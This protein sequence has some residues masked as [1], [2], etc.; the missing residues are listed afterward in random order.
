MK[1]KI[2]IWCPFKK[3]PSVFF[4]LY[5]TELFEADL[6]IV[7]DWK[8]KDDAAKTSLRKAYYWYLFLLLFFSLEGLVLNVIFF[9]FRHYATDLPL[10]TQIDKEED[11]DP[12]VKKIYVY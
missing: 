9:N 7:T 3:K 10:S 1:S 5:V 6:N 11:D 2:N 12:Q 8:F 4:L